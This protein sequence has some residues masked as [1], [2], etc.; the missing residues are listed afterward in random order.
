[1]GDFVLIKDCV[2]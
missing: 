1:M 2:F